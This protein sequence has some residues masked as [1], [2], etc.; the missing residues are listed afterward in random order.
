MLKKLSTLLAVAMMAFT[1]SFSAQAE[2][3][4]FS[5]G[6]PSSYSGSNVSGAS[7][8]GTLV[9]VKLPSFIGFG[10]ESYEITSG[11]S[12]VKTT[13]FD[14]FYLLPIPLINVTL[15]LGA[16]TNEPTGDLSGTYTAGSA[17]QGY[18]QLGY[19]FGPVDVHLSQHIVT[20]D[21]KGSTNL[22][23]SGTMT[24]VGVQIG[25]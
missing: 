7:V 10:M 24:A 23:T 12:G 14:I 15:G 11:G 4:T 19:S 5:A 25:F 9:H 3:L 17:A 20:S 16:G 13:M 1:F 8:S 18:L 2:T 22:D 21:L 6:I